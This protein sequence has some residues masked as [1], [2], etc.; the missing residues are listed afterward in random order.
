M[1]KWFAGC[2][3]VKLFELHKKTKSKLQVPKNLP[4]IQ[5][6]EFCNN[7]YMRHTFWSCLIRWV[8]MKWIRLVLWK[9]QNGHGFVHRGTDGQTDGRRE[10]SIPPVFQ[11]TASPS[12]R[13]RQLWRRTGN[14]SYNF[15]QFYIYD[16][17]FKAGGL[18]TFL[19]EFWTLIP[20]FQLRWS[21]AI[22]MFAIEF[23]QKSD[24]VPGSN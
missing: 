5:I 10:T 16:L 11:I 1:N 2:D 20:P 6:L 13:S 12:A 24:Q 9:I 18:T 3:N 14:F 23:H 4:K 17:R 19:T 8:I 21:G 22:K 15:L 7:P